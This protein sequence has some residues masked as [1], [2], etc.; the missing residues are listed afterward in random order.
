[1]P[2][3]AKMDLIRAKIIDVYQD[4]L[5]ALYSYQDYSEFQSNPLLV[6]I[7]LMLI[8]TAY[9]PAVLDAHYKLQM[10]FKKTAFKQ[11]AIHIKL[12]TQ[13]ELLKSLDVFPL[14]FLDLKDSRKLLAGSDILNLLDVSA[15]N[16]R[17]ECEFYLRSHILKLR[18]G[19]IH[20]NRDVD[21][22]IRASLP[23][24]FSIFRHLL[25]LLNIPVPKTNDEVIQSLS[26][27]IPF[28]VDVFI[29]VLNRLS[30]KDLSSHFYSY[31]TELTVIVRYVDALPDN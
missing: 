3:L 30:Q 18:E 27:I 9:S 22:L 8:A 4:Q 25:H 31:L 13:E 12:F 16:L 17:H 5:V 10:A 29:T 1:M 14:E 7:H 2:Q 26:Q 15:V 23:S 11:Q 21:Y 6:P 20:P 24:L 28:K 19:F